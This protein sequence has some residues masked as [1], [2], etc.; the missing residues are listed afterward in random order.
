ME[1]SG[2]LAQQAPRLQLME[3]RSENQEVFLHYCLQQFPDI[4]YAK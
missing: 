2:F 1:G 4:D 3:V